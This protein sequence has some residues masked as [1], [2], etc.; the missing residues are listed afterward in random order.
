MR[1][2]TTP[3]RRASGM[4][5][6][7]WAVVALSV[8]LAVVFASRFGSD[9]ALSESPLLG[10]PA[11]EVTLPRLLGSGEVSLSD[12]SGEI[13]VVKDRKSVV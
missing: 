7:A 1:E 5:I 9:P 2:L 11:P 3:R 8:V 6:A 12:Y 13:V 10:R 4:K